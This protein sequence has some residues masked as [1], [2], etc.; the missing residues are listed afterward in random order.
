MAPEIE[1]SPVREEEFETL[2]PLI[3]AYQ[4]FYEVVDV[5]VD[6][7]RFFFRRF[8]APSDVGLLLAARDPSGVIRGYACLYWHFSSLQ[9]LEVVLMND[10]FVAPEARGQGIGRALIEATAQV[11]RERG[12][13]WVEWSTAPDNHTAQRLYDSLTEHKST[14]LSY[15]LEA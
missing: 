9:A 3:A 5:D 7:N 2:L 4:R 1:I 12:S 11:A 13:A 14:W 8:L 6:R 15:E 10:L